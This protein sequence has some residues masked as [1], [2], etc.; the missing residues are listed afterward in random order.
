MRKFSPT[1]LAI[2]ISILV[3]GLFMWPALGSNV[4]L[5]YDPAGRLV[6]AEYGTNRTASYAYDN[7]G[8]LL[9]SSAPAPAIIV[10][11]I[12]SG[13]VT[14]SWPASPSG[15]T[16]QQATVLGPSPNWADAGVTQSQSG[17]FVIATVPVGPGTV[18]YRLKK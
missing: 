3:A 5:T 18:F 14:L 8:N 16:L 11:P 12:A 6:S 17:N 2:K 7:A 10:G 1:T 4:A 15:F 13:Q 9:L